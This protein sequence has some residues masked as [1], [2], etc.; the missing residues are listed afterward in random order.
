MKER[1]TLAQ[2]LGLKAVL[3]VDKVTGWNQKS[4]EPEASL[5]KC[6]PRG[7]IPA[8]LRP[9]CQPGEYQARFKQY[10]VIWMRMNH[11]LGPL[12]TWISPSHPTPFGLAVWR[13][14]RSWA[15][16]RKCVPGVLHW[17]F[18]DSVPF[19][20]LFALC[21]SLMTGALSFQLLPTG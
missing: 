17:E 6:N 7:K 2:C 8:S 15:L 11:R 1:K 10:I 5:A 12:S 13:N 20:L 4:G 9:A 3:L 19:H 16:L 21:L 18:K 14:F